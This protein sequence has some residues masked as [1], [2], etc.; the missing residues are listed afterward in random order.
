MKRAALVGAAMVGMAALADVPAAAQTGGSQQPIAELA[1]DL[2]YGMCPQ[3]LQGEAALEG[4]ADLQARG[5]PATARR[6][7]HR[8]GE[9][10]ILGQTRADGDV[11]ISSVDRAL[12]QVNVIGTSA[13]KAE[14]LFRSGIG[15]L[16]LT[17]EPDVAKNVTHPTEDVRGETFVARLSSTQVIMVQFTS[18]TV[19]EVPFAGFQMFV[20]DR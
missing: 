4:N 11:T 2:A 18:G 14:A 12:C 9:V 10:A 20:Q 15:D 6:R 16:G 8:L 5:F 7:E 17:F 19:R 3:L 13:D 1:A